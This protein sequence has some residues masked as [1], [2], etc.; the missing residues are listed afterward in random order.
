MLILNRTG[1]QLLEGA[2]KHYRGRV[3]MLKM[4]SNTLITTNKKITDSLDMY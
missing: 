4:N 3:V 2:W 1:R